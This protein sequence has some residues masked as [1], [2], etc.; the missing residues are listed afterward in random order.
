MLKASPGFPSTGCDFCNRNK[1][2]HYCHEKCSSIDARFID[3]SSNYI[4]GRAFCVSCQEKEGIESSRCCP[5]CFKKTEGNKEYTKEQ[6]LTMNMIELKN[7]CK[8]KNIDP[9]KKKKQGCINA[10]LKQQGLLNK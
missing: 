8:H 7:I 2:K 9:G 6:L 10:V 1:T 4:C 3:E 5:V